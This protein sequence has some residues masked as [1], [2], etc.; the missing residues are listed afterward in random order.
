MAKYGFVGRDKRG[1]PCIEGVW[2]E[3]P[4]H[5]I[6][7]LGVTAT[8]VGMMALSGFV[9]WLTKERHTEA[10]QMSLL[11]GSIAAMFGGGTLYLARLRQ[12]ILS[13]FTEQEICRRCQIEPVKLAHYVQEGELRP[14]FNINSVDFYDIEEV[15]CMYQNECQPEAIPPV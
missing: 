10:L 3:P 14:V 8:L 2:D 13:L 4:V 11:M 15:R 7:M 5:I 1:V 9:S 6:F 12:R